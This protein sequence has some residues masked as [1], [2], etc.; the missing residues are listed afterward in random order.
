MGPVFVLFTVIILALAGLAVV[1]SRTGFELPAVATRQIGTIAATV[2]ALAGLAA[3]YRALRSSRRLTAVVAG[4]MLGPGAVWCWL[5]FV[6]Q[7]RTSQS[8]T[9]A[10]A[11]L[12]AAL[13]ITLLAQGLRFAHWLEVFSGLGSLSLLLVTSMVGSLPAPHVTLSLLAAFGGM[14]ALYGT[15][16]DF[17]IAEERSLVELVESKRHIEEEMQRAEELLHDLRSGLLAIE[18]AIGSFDGE[19]AEPLRS[20]AA[21]LRRLTLRGQRT[22]DRFDLVRHVRNLIETREAS[23]AAFEFFAPSSANVWGEQSEVLAIVDNLLS[24]AQRHGHR[25]PIRVEI[26]E[27]G[28]RTTLSVSN[29]GQGVADPVAIF[30]RGFTSHPDGQGLGLSRAK[31]LAEM[32]RGELALVSGRDGRTTFTLELSDDPP[33][34]V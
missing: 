1:E 8:V 31:L 15:L 24:N 23:G 7:T 26:T 10:V 20:E 19:L 21:R 16:V 4:V 12:A 30:R 18:A 13:A 5:V 9:S 32:N 33:V 14:A 34:A 3:A 6:A 22:I 28:G 29:R 27:G 17:E 11:L 2:Y 25:T